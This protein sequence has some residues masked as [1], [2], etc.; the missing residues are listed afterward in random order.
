MVPP[1]DGTIGPG[2]DYEQYLETRNE[3]HLDLQGV[4]DRWYIKRLSGREYMRL[5][6]A[7]HRLPSGEQ[8]PDGDM[9]PERAAELRAAA[10]DVE[11]FTAAV[12]SEFV[13]GF[14]SFEYVIGVA[15]DGSDEI[16]KVSLAKGE[17]PDCDMIELIAQDSDM[18]NYIFSFGMRLASLSSAEKKD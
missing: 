4:P 7:V 14:D 2:A 5:M 11:A 8:S 18:I 3:A 16:E 13:R 15:P 9:T 12:I 17:T 10:D 6:E 1:D